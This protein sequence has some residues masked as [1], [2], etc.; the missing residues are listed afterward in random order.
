VTVV[1]VVAVVNVAKVVTMVTSGDSGDSGVHK[2]LQFTSS[3]LSFSAVSLKKAK[4]RNRN[5]KT[6]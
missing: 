6:H 5:N 3:S 1:T 2:R 4:Y